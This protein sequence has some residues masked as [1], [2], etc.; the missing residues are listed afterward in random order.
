MQATESTVAIQKE[1]DT[2]QRIRQ[3]CLQWW[4]KPTDLTPEYLKEKWVININEIMDVVVKLICEF[5]WIWL[6]ELA[7]NDRQFLINKYWIPED[8]L[9]ILYDNGDIWLAYSDFAKMYKGDWD[10]A[11]SIDVQMP[12]T[13]TVVNMP[14]EDIKREE[15]KMLNVAKANIQQMLSTETD[16]EKIELYK[17][18][19]KVLELKLK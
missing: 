5:Y 13:T 14:E 16:P 17:A 18:Q 7:R 10:N 3:S 1:N 4:V 11:K 8:K 9:N 15:T 19:L 12:T 2:R 6:W